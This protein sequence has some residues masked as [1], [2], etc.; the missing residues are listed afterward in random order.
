[1]IQAT[2]QN[3]KRFTILLGIVLTLITLVP[4]SQVRDVLE[5]T[6]DW[7]GLPIRLR[8][9][10]SFKAITPA[11]AST[12]IA[13]AFGSPNESELLPGSG[14]HACAMITSPDHEVMLCEADFPEVAIKSPLTI[15]QDRALFEAAYSLSATALSTDEVVVEELPSVQRSLLESGLAVMS[16]VRAFSLPSCDLYGIYLEKPEAIQKKSVELR[17]WGIGPRGGVAIFGKFRSIDQLE[18]FF[19]G[20]E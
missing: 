12:F 20:R 7:H 13:D 11:S 19:V 6:V 16:H 4:T 18:R 1:M 9:G 3:L 17:A 14:S 5:P 10:E 2:L 8:S 15:E